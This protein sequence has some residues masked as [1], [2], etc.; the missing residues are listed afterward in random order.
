VTFC[1]RLRLAWS[2]GV[3]SAAVFA[4]LALSVP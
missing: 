2:L 4:V 1:A 3:L